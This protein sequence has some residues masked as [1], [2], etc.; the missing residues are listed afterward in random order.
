MTCYVVKKQEL[1]S[2]P[3]EPAP[4]RTWLRKLLEQRHEK[5]MS[6]SRKS[7]PSKRVSLVYTFLG[8]PPAKTASWKPQPE[9]SASEK[10]TFS[11][12]GNLQQHS[13]NV[14]YAKIFDLQIVVH[15]V[16]RAFS[17]QARLLDATEW[18]VL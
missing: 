14:A 4:A 7:A 3:Y 6:V 2:N 17:A 16:M 18:H 8:L 1:S 13:K 9:S 11:T 5:A 12:F 15:R 10:S